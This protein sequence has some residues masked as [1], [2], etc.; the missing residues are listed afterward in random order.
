MLDGMGCR[1]VDGGRLNAKFVEVG[2]KP[3]SG[4]GVRQAWFLFE[5]S[6]QNNLGGSRRT[7][8]V[9]NI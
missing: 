8:P 3:V 6:V 1:M 5:I 9:A 7:A 4:D 2:K